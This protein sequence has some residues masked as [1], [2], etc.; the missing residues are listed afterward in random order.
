VP[1]AAHSVTILAAA[2]AAIIIIIIIIINNLQILTRTLENRRTARH[3]GISYL[4]Q[5]SQL[6][7]LFFI[8]WP[9]N[10]GYTNITQPLG[11]RQTL[12]LTSGDVMTMISFSS[13]NV[14][15]WVV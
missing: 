6:W 14:D 12:T 2:A 15:S 13:D 1:N 3:P 4:T 8:I 7:V 11:A 10:E 9:Y 5:P